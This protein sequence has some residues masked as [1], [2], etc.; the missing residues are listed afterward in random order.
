MDIAPLRRRL[1]ASLIDMT[2]LV[3]TTVAL[4]VGGVAW[5]SI[6]ARVKNRGEAA[7]AGAVKPRRERRLSARHRAFL[8]LATVGLGVLSRNWRGPGFR[9]LRLRRVDMHT[10]GPVAVRSAVIVQVCDQLW[11]LSSRRLARGPLRRQ[12]QR[13]RENHEALEDIRRKFAADPKARKQAVDSFLEENPS[14]SPST[15]LWPLLP[16]A[17][18]RV[19]S[20]LW[21][22]EGRTLRDRVAGTAVVV[23]R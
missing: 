2:L 15:L 5:P 18:W 10:G 22:R 6:P 14:I 13:S 23:E 12:E 16:E 7:G 1:L 8:F 4:I 3:L 21:V 20:I 17:L 19:L 9:L 11:G